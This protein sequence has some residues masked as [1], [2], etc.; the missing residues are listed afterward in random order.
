MLGK[1]NEG[2]LWRRM[3]RESKEGEAAELNASLHAGNFLTG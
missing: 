2:L 3:R 1:E